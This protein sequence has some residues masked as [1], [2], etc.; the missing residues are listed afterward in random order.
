MF[1]PML[2]RLLISAVCLAPLAAPVPG[3]AAPLDFAFMP[4]D[5]VPQ[6]ICAAPRNPD[7][8]PSEGTSPE[9]MT[10]L[11]LFYLRRD[12]RN[13]SA[14]DADGWFAFILDLLA[15]QEELDPAFAGASADLAR[16][17]LHVDAGRQDALR[18]TGLLDGLRAMAADL[19][20]AQKVAL[21]QYYLDGIGTD[22]DL[23]FAQGLIRDAAYGG[24][25]E[26]LLTIARIDRKS[27]V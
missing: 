5:I 9:V 2:R 17:R 15:W 4:P 6:D 12:I 1:A 27:V 16:A 8:V 7:A 10:E 3:Q 13:L 23:P 26:A 20:G 25:V 24:N 19:N 14:E 22:P 21:A 11:F 18:A